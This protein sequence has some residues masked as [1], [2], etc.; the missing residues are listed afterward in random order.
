MSRCIASESLIDEDRLTDFPEIED[1]LIA[2]QARSELLDRVVNFC[3]LERGDPEKQKRVMGMKNP[4]YHD[5]ARATINL[6]L[7][8]HSIADEI[9]LNLNIVNG[10][11]S[12]HM[13]L[14]LPL[15]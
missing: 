10:H 14:S 13:K 4:Y 7:P 3:G 12:K 1:S 6:P 5:P 15:S 8:W 11:I 2:K 9:Q